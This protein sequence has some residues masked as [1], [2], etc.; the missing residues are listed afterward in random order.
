M[1]VGDDDW[2]AVDG[3]VQKARKSWGQMS[4]KFEPGGGGPKDIGALFQGGSTGGVYFRGR[5]VG[6]DPPDV[7]G[8]VQ[9]SSQGCAKDHRESAEE[10]GGWDL[11]LSS[12]GGGNGGSRIRGDR[13]NVTRRQNTFAQYLA[14]QP[15]MD[16]CEQSVWR[17]GAWVSW[18]WW[19]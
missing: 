16:L 2:P 14:T 10:A 1:T 18:R 8:P 4:R 6:P 19:D 9:L 5:D 7:S 17:K 15:I 11:G 3:N 13:V 12:T